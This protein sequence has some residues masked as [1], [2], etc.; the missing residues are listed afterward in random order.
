MQLSLKLMPPKALIL[1]DEASVDL[2][3][4]GRESLLAFLKSDSMARNVTVIYCTHIFDGL[5]SWGTE[6]LFV[7][8]GT[9][10]T[11]LP[12]ESVISKVCFL[13]FESVFSKGFFLPFEK[14]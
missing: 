11:N 7:T 6:L 2:D 4:L 10:S 1:L 9:I 14:I 5:D 3:I 13:T 8:N 12:F